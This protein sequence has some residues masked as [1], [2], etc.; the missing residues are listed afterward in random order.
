MYNYFISKRNGF[1]WTKIGLSL[2]IK[3]S[4]QLSIIKSMFFNKE[5]FLVL[6]NIMN[7]GLS[8]EKYNKNF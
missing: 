3:D 1:N 8:S 6:D 7:A 5:N 2:I 4:F